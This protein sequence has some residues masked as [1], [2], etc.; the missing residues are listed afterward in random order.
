MASSNAIESRQR[1]RRCDHHFRASLSFL[2]TGALACVAYGE[3]ARNASSGLS[4]ADTAI[5]V[6]A[7]E[8]AP[9]LTALKVG[10]NIWKNSVSESLPDQMEVGG[11]GGP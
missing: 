7:G 11:T 4:T 8:H 5:L 1:V 9:L 10:K 2:L 3:A 6:Q